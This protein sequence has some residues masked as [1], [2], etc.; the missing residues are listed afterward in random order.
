MASI[1]YV[2]SV[3]L[4]DGKC[5][6][7]WYYGP[8]YFLLRANKRK[9]LTEMLQPAINYCAEALLYFEYFKKPFF[10]VKLLNVIVNLTLVYEL[11]IFGLF[12]MIICIP[13]TVC[14]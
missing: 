5:D 3:I 13:F 14:F 7:L 6:S 1:N 10:F 11:V 12:S 9:R 2:L 4:K 8:T